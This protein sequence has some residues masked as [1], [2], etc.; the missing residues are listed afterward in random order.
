MKLS[1]YLFFFTIAGWLVMAFS[2]GTS[3]KAVRRD[4]PPPAAPA[5]KTNTG[6]TETTANVLRTLTAEIYHKVASNHIDFNTFSAKAKIDFENAKGSQQGITAYVRMQKD[7][8]IWI[9]VRPLLGIEL[10]R[11]LIT[12]DSVKIIDYFKKTVYIHPLN[13]LQQ[14]INIPYDFQTLQD[15]IIGNPVYFSDSISE[16]KKTP[17]VISFTCTGQ[18]Y[19]NRFNVFSDDFL[20][21][22]NKLMN[23]DTM[24]FR[25][26]DLTYGDY[27]QIN[28]RPF[29]SRR[30][31]FVADKNVTQLLIDFNKVDFNQPVSFPFG[32]S[33]KYDIQ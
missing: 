21:Q 25:S 28:G 17:S 30:K 26:C 8:T 32:I 3:R 1:R 20:L 29:S 6:A 31:I 9:S 23:S 18:Q 19:V 13:Y 14:L 24:N 16:V 2:C 12:P 5:P 7:S 22:E 4:A 15:L 10:I 27:K 33:S 11:V